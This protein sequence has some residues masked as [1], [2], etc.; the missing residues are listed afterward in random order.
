MGL[1]VSILPPESEEDILYMRNHDSFFAMMCSG[2][3]EHVYEGY[4]DF[5]VDAWVLD[6]VEA[7]LDTRWPAIPADRT[8]TEAELGKLLAHGDE[9]LPAEI[10]K[11]FYAQ[12]IEMLRDAL[13]EHGRLVCS[14]SA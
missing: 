13:D 14:W 8:F 6:R 11:P 2:G 3:T 1:D 12:V 9:D 7:A 10:L 4:T 5:F